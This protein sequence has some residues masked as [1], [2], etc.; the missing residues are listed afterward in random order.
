MLSERTT[1]LLWDL[2]GTIL[3]SGE[4]HYESWKRALASHGFPLDREVFYQYFGRNNQ[5]SLRLYLGFEPD[6]DMVDAVLEEKE[7]YFR[8][9]APR[10]AHLV[11]GVAS[12]LSNAQPRQ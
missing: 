11:K 3:D 1:A 4:C 2:D 12:W 6:P 8:Q 5:A 7:N 10:K 9:I